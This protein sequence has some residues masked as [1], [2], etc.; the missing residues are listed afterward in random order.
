MTKASLSSGE[1]AYEALLRALREGTYSP[2]DRLRE[3][4]VAERL[5]FSRT[6]VREALRRLE[7]HG[8]VEH[9]PR[10]GAV[11]RT[12]EHAEIVEF[13]EMRVVLETLAAQMAAQHGSEAEFDTLQALNDRIEA[14]QENPALGAAV[15]QQFH[16]NLYLTAR[17]RFLL[18]SAR[19][20]NHSLMLLGPTTYSNP[21][22]H[23]VVVSEHAAIIAALRLRDKAGAA[24]AVNAHLQSSLRYRLRML[25]S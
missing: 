16:Q 12:L 20:L 9:R 4:E 2:G 18:E 14:E 5:G 13:Y 22:R 7:A 1:L 23:N 8:V 19:A 15:N 24:A 3:E 17:N 25:A 11:I 10:T 6:P 21:D